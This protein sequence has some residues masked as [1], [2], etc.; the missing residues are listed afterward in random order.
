M[1]SQPGR[2]QRSVAGM[3]GAM[4]VLVLVVGAFVTARETYRE[5]P[6]SPVRALDYTKPAE[7]ARGEAEF[8]LLAP[9]TVPQ[10]WI[11]T[12]VRFVN[13]RD[14]SWHLSF[15]TEE[16]RYVGLK[17]ADQS[18]DGMVEE[19][20]DEDAEQGKDVTIRGQTW[21][22]WSDSGGDSALVREDGEVTTL[23]LGSASPDVLEE[24]VRSLR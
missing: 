8:D 1:S 9:A 14:Q 18:P 2:Y 4:L 24:F 3:V 22:S 6:A 11:A 13:G 5:E 20:V 15:L 7:Y 12:N 23:V 16:G 19:F 21:Q 17:Q 10:G